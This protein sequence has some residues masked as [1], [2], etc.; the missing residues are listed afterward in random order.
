MTKA[1]PSRVNDTV[2]LAAF[3]VALFAAIVAFTYGGS[4]LRDLRERRL[5]TDGLAAP[6][7][8][9]AVVPTGNFFNNQPEMRISLDVRPPQGEPFAADVIRVV[10]IADMP[11]LA[12][13]QAVTVRYSAEPP[14][15]VAIAP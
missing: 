4:L 1:E 7:Q 6:A 8:V 5:L 3:F 13:G 14:R 15:H 2:L 12:P 10:G 9:T 11:R